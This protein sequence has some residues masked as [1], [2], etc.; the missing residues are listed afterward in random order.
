MR[1]WLGYFVRQHG[2]SSAPPFFKNKF[3]LWI[4]KLELKESFGD[5][6]IPCLKWFYLVRK[7]CA[8]VRTAQTV[9]YATTPISLLDLWISTPYSTQN[10]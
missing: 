10:E 3:E 2:G 9:G 6:K 4:G 1:W 7:E 5:L 8:L